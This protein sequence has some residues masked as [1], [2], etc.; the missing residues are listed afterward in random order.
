[1][2]AVAAAVILPAAVQAQSL[3]FRTGQWG[4]EFQSGDLT[5]AGVMRFFSPS[6]ALVLNVGIL[7]I[8]TEEE[9]TSAGPGS[10][11]TTD[12]SFSLYAAR[13]GFRNYSPVANRVVG[14]WTVGVELARGSQEQFVPDPFSGGGIQFEESETQIGVFG[15]LGADYQ[16]TSNLAVG[17][18]FDVV[19]AR[20]TGE[21]RDPSNTVDISG[22]RFSGNLT[23]VRVSIFF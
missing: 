21:Q 13:L 4:A 20:I 9:V 8:E 23:P 12:N 10:G 2:L 7:S 11:T 14:F 22:H 6:T 19:W 18:A 3:P 16:V 1:M 17:M 5:S 15:Q